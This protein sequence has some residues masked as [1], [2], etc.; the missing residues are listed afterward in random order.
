[1]PQNPK[2][3]KTHF[4]KVVLKIYADRYETLQISEDYVACL[5][6]EMNSSDKICKV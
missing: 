4:N 2:L 5:T 6:A 3:R 1:M